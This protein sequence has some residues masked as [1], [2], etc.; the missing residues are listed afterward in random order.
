MPATFAPLCSLTGPRGR[1]VVVTKAESL[2]VWAFQLPGL[3]PYQVRP[4]RRCSQRHAV[5]LAQ[6]YA[7]RFC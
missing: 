4:A 6:R 5:A 3:R 2:G 7:R 1:S